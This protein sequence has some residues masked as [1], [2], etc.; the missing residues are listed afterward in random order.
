IFCCQRTP[1]AGNCDTASGPG[2]E[3][4]ASRFI[5]VSAEFPC[6]FMLSLSKHQR[7]TTSYPLSTMNC[8]PGISKPLW[9][10]QFFI[11]ITGSINYTRTHKAIPLAANHFFSPNSIS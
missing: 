10:K 6:P 2:Q 1:P 4:C 9:Q 5:A 3:G 7:K 8:K 11:D